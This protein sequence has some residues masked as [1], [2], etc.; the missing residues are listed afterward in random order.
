MSLRGMVNSLVDALVND[1]DLFWWVSVSPSSIVHDICETH[2]PIWTAEYLYVS[3]FA[4][5]AAVSTT[6]GYGHE[7]ALADSDHPSDY[8]VGACKFIMY[9][10][11]E[12]RQRLNVPDY[13][14]STY[15]HL[16][17]I[18]GPIDN[19]EKI[20]KAAWSMCKTGVRLAI[21]WIGATATYSQCVREAL[22]RY[23]FTVHSLDPMG[24]TNDLGYF[25]S[26]M[27][28]VIED[29]RRNIKK[30]EAVRDSLLGW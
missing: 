12:S 19:V 9:G 7:V 10:V 13:F 6:K 17:P 16:F 5:L 21:G 1:P 15:G 28:N 30:T 8:T 25:D 26:V 24:V 29:C 3:F 18:G 23:G 2:V 14:C 11:N 4:L 22:Y 27:L 20:I